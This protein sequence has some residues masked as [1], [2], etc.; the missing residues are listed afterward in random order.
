MY[1]KLAEL[2]KN[3]R[4]AALATVVAGENLGAKLLVS[5]EGMVAG[6]IDAEVDAKIAGDALA[7]LAEEQSR[8]QKYDLGGAMLDVFIETFPPPQRLIIIGG[9]HV[10]IPLHHIAKLLGYHVTVV[11]ARGIL[12]TR[13]RFPHADSILVEWPDDAL[14]ALRLDTGASVVVL[15]HDPKFDYSALLAAIQSPAR[16]VGAIGSKNTNVKRMDALRE[17]GATDEQLSRIFAPVGLDLGAKS[18]SEIA[19]A[20]MAEIVAQRYNRMGGHLKR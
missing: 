2:L 3:N 9:V 12:A 5:T 17:M 11:D 16:Y 20:V 4:P 10:A 19:L 18:P 14:A 15:T 13:E 7:L 1:E 8:L 6:G